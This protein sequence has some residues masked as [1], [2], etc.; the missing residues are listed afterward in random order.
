MFTVLHKTYKTKG[1]TRL[2]HKHIK[3]TYKTRLTHKHIK[4]FLAPMAVLPRYSTFLMTIHFYRQKYITLIT[5]TK[6]S[7]TVALESQS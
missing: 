6:P 7:M 3:Y 4:F 2:T 1:K 5:K